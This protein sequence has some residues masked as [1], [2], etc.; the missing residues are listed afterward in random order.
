MQTSGRP[1][2]QDRKEITMKLITRNTWLVAG[3]LGI[4]AIGGGEIGR[5]HV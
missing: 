5:A 3:S 1:G 4:V 2:G